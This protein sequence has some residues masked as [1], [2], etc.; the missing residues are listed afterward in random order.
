MK[1]KYRRFDDNDYTEVDVVYFQFSNFKKPNDTILRLYLK[2]TDEV[3]R[4]VVD[5]IVDIENVCEVYIEEI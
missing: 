4:T 5:K 1:I 2:V 3:M